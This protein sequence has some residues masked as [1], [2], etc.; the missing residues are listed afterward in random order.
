LKLYP[1][2]SAGKVPEMFPRSN[3]LSDRITFVTFPAKCSVKS[4]DGRGWECGR[5]PIYSWRE[6]GFESQADC[7]TIN[8]SPVVFHNGVCLFMLNFP[9]RKTVI[10][11]K[12]LKRFSCRKSTTSTKARTRPE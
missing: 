2:L 5:K 8:P 12:P 11:I 4:W 10:T 1:L 3:F 9:V 6:I 7:R